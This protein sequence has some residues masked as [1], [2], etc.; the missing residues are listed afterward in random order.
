MKSKGKILFELS[1]FSFY[2]SLGQPMKG[3]RKWVG[4]LLNGFL[5]SGKGPKAHQAEL[6]AACTPSA[7]RAASSLTYFRNWAF[8]Q[9]F[10]WTKATILWQKWL[11]AYQL[12][13]FPLL[14]LEAE[15]PILYEHSVVEIKHHIPQYSLKSDMA[16]W[17]ILVADINESVWDFP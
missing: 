17:P 3:L 7:G 1:S 4:K 14:P 9:D 16:T 6:Q 12:T 8:K 11:A 2:K 10:S 15:L 13:I 5:D